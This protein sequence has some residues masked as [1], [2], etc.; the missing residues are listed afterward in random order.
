[1]STFV[2]EDGTGL[3]N[4]TSYVSLA[5]ANSYIADFPAGLQV[6]WSALTDPQKQGL[7]MY[8]TRVLDQRTKYFGDL[9]VTPGALRWPRDG[10]TD[11]DGQPVPNDVI[12]DGLKM[13]VI[14]LALFYSVP[15]RG[16]TI[17]ADNQ[18]LTNVTIDVLSFTWSEGF[19]ATSTLQLPPG[20][21]VILCGLGRI[22]Y[23]GSSRTVPILKV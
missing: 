22:S 5:E 3:S 7:L 1:M 14:E 15:G 17:Y 6:T 8:S 9:C 20:M 2:V 4:A 18:G 19:N 13:A 16:A 11:C 21:N 23:T 10:V 12:P